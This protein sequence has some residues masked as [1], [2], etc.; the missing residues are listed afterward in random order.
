MAENDHIQKIIDEARNLMNFGF[1]FKV[2]VL[3][4]INVEVCRYKI[5]NA[6]RIIHISPDYVDDKKDFVMFDLVR[7]LMAMHNK[8]ALYAERHYRLIDVVKFEDF[9]EELLKFLFEYCCF[10]MGNDV[11]KLYPGVES[12]FC[13][14]RFDGL[15]DLSTPE[16]RLFSIP[17]LID[18]FLAIQHLYIVRGMLFS[19]FGGKMI[20]ILLLLRFCSVDEKYSK[21]LI[22]MMTTAYATTKANNLL[23]L[24]KTFRNLKS[25]YAKYV[26]V[27]CGKCMSE[28]TIQRN[29][30]FHILTCFNNKILL[31]EKDKLQ[32]QKHMPE[33]ICKF[34]KKF[35]DKP[36][37]YYLIV[38]RQCI[39]IL[40]MPNA[41]KWI[42]NVCA[43]ILRSLFTE[44]SQLPV[45]VL[46][47]Y[48][49]NRY[50][51]RIRS[52]S[53]KQLHDVIMDEKAV[54]SF[55]SLMDELMTVVTL[56]DHFDE[57]LQIIVPVLLS[58]N[59]DVRN[60]VTYCA[61]LI[62]DIMT[63]LFDTQKPAAFAKKLMAWLC[64]R[65]EDSLLSL[66][67]KFVIG[68]RNGVQAVVV[69]YDEDVE[70]INRSVDSFYAI[71][72]SIQNKNNIYSAVLEEWLKIIITYSF[73]AEQEEKQQQQQSQ[74]PLSFL[75]IESLCSILDTHISHFYDLFSTHAVDFLNV[76]RK[77][78]NWL[79]KRSHKSTPLTNQVADFLLK[80]VGIFHLEYFLSQKD[81]LETFQS[82]I[83]VVKIY[84]EK[85]PNSSIRAT[86]AKLVANVNCKKGR[87]DDVLLQKC[88]EAYSKL[89][90]EEQSRKVETFQTVM[91]DLNSTGVEIKGHALIM[92]RRLI[93]NGDTHAMMA[94]E[95]KSFFETLCTELRDKDSY[96]YLLTIK[97][98]AEA[99]KKRK[100]NVFPFLLQMFDDM[101]SKGDVENC[102]KIGEAV[103]SVIRSLGDV[104]PHYVEQ[105]LNRFLKIYYTGE[106]NVKVSCLCI[107]AEIVKSASYKIMMFK[108]ELLSLIEYNLKIQKWSVL[109]PA[110]VHLLHNLFLGAEGKLLE[111]YGDRLHSIYR[112]LK[113]MYEKELDNVEIEKATRLHIQLCIEQLNRELK[114]C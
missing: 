106:C 85:Y 55:L 54:L 112:E 70:F 83:R 27:F 32:W 53:D 98:L 33:L 41:D 6:K 73:A 89:S 108:V 5:S 104:T 87:S 39:G 69:S 25:R 95:K 50:V 113:R 1:S 65:I 93:E 67:A 20:A 4:K 34:P 64:S 99:C 56:D 24:M 38:F 31:N 42:K 22:N 107:I 21:A 101:Q 79:L 58:M 9:N 49:K 84:S 102:L 61:P 68:R 23:L 44:K 30:I 80:F 15:W 114:K 71:L 76:L 46:N 97:V 12:Y 52:I 45:S 92:L 90:E 16:K 72:N 78:L 66:R 62:S 48:I 18:Y 91:E 60:S 3:R 59:C 74:L 86:A 88:Q 40:E 57:V 109:L 77:I 82:V 100:A 96:V 35:K 103:A 110:S 8:V 7:V 10:C 47:E 2:K 36:M 19:R 81:I 13:H 28:I 51:D 29:G 94:L 75:L 37:K 63:N 43:D 17:T 105:V 26:L 11:V 111:I 14:K